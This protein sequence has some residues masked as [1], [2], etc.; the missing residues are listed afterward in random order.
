MKDQVNPFD[1]SIISQS[2]CKYDSKYLIDIDEHTFSKENFKKQA[3]AA[4]HAVAEGADFVYKGAKKL[5]HYVKDSPNKEGGNKR[6]TH[7]V[8]EEDE[9]DNQNFAGVNFV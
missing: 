3:K 7:T 1:L 9:A 2:G 6:P 8:V 5:Y 4:A